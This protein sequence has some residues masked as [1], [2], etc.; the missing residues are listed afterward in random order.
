MIDTKYQA[1]EYF[2]FLCKICARGGCANCNEKSCG[3]LFFADYAYSVN[4]DIIGVIK[5]YDNFP[6][7]NPVFWSYG[8]EKEIDQPSKYKFMLNFKAY[9]DKNP[10]AEIFKDM[11][12][13]NRLDHY[14]NKAV[15]NSFFVRK[16]DLLS[17]LN[18]YDLSAAK[19][20]K[21]KV[22]STGTDAE[23]F[24]L[25][26]VNININESTNTNRV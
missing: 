17:R 13:I 2:R 10:V 21:M 25:L 3:V 1:V 15:D 22:Q 14:L 23:T 4:T 12:F 5:I 19:Q 18:R 6:V 9:V 7:I 20:N 11:N 24:V 26:I 16:N 8:R